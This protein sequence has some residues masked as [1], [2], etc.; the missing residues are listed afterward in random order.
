MENQRPIIDK[1]I[2]IS[3]GVV[4]VVGGLIY[5]YAVTNTSVSSRLAILEENQEE[6]RET[7]KS[8]PE[9]VAEQIEKDNDN[10]SDRFDNFYDSL[11]RQGTRLDDVETRLLLIER[12]LEE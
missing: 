4:L 2:G 1:G 10:I 6:I 9:A 8:L 3:L 7:L 5:Q 11:V 12:E